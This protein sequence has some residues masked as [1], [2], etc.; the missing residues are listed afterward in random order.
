[1]TSAEHET[2]K[3]AKSAEK[4]AKTVAQVAHVQH[5][6]I[7][8]TTDKLAES[9][10]E[11]AHSTHRM[12][13]TT[14]QMADSS[15]RRT[16]L[17]ADRTVF[18]AERT[19]AAW[20]R[21]GLAALASGIGAKALLTGNVVGWMVQ[22]AGTVLT[23]FSAFCFLAGVWRGIVPGAPPPIPDVRRIPIWM[24]CIVNGFLALVSLAALLN[25]WSIAIP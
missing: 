13:N 20:V 18:A 10:G 12:A 11:M 19:Y 7:R 25:I 15:D 17:A 5:E 1:M 9:T 24:L 21:T 8:K 14:V 2:A 3:A 6:Q 16:E 23:L 22:G 4:A